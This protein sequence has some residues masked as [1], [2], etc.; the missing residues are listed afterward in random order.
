MGDHQLLKLVRMRHKAL[1]R[2]MFVFVVLLALLNTGESLNTYHEQQKNTMTFTQFIEEKKRAAK[3]HDTSL[4]NE[5]YATYLKEQRY[6]VMPQRDKLYSSLVVGQIITI[7][8]YAIP[9]LLGLA[10]AGMDQAS[11]FNVAMFKSR[12]KRRQF[13]AARYWYGLTCLLG[14]T[15]LGI[16]ILLLG[17]FA[18][19]PTEY[20]GIS[21]LN[22]LGLLMMNLAIDSFL[23]TVGIGVG[24]IFS[25][26]FGM[27]V[28]GLFGGWLGAS[29]I[30]RFMVYNAVNH[31]SYWSLLPRGDQLFL[32]L[33]ILA[34]TISVA[35]YWLTRWLFDRI[36][37]E[38]EGDILL[39]PKLR[40]VIF[41]YALIVVP[42]NFGDWLFQNELLSY[43]VS[44]IG[45]LALGL[46]WLHRE[47]AQEQLMVR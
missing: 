20:V 30:Q 14:T 10:M 23:F 15:T 2:V 9:L 40:W 12:F 26:L 19:V 4:V 33:F 11:S 32:L 43:S 27:F 38:N 17:I 37:L 34:L 39:L 28:F 1:V 7:I 31:R 46:W 6:F 24:S 36:S 5:S 35:G 13:F 29:A 44:I 16:G 8:H 42:F 47:R 25:T 21:G 45:V 18:G 22:I 3:Y 41:V